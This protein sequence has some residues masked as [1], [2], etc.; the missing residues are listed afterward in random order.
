M[1]QPGGLGTHRPFTAE[2]LSLTVPRAGGIRKMMSN[3]TADNFTAVSR[4]RPGEATLVLLLSRF[5]TVH[6]CRLWPPTDSLGGF[7]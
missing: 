3:N 5:S 2:G 6:S 1:A 7:H 4:Q